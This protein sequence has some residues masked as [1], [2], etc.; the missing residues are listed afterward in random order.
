MGLSAPLPDALYK[1]HIEPVPTEKS[2]SRQ[3]QEEQPRLSR[4]VVG[5]SALLL[6]KGPARW[7]SSLWL[8]SIGILSGDLEPTEAYSIHSFLGLGY[9][10]KEIRLYCELFSHRSLLLQ[11]NGNSSEFRCGEEKVGLSEALPGS[12]IIQ[13]S[14]FR[15]SII[16]WGEG[17]SLHLFITVLSTYPLKTTEKGP[18]CRAS[19]SD[20]L[21]ITSILPA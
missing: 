8:N 11:K 7:L 17:S 15:A 13:G 2:V 4:S 10:C 5:S 20:A 14:E 9:L 3:G 12:N 21:G 16:G 1:S 6:A 18:T 19:T